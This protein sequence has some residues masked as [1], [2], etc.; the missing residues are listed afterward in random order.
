MPAK[1][2]ETVVVAFRLPEESIETLD[3][4]AKESGITRSILLRN[5]VQSWLEDPLKIRA[6]EESAYVIKNIVRKAVTIAINDAY[7]R[8]PAFIEEEL[9]KS[10]SGEE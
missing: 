7:A 3:L 9:A 5:I 8:L 4:Q 10:A 2:P 6:T 1:P